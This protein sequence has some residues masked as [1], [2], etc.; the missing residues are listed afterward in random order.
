MEE[1]LQLAQNGKVDKKQA[2]LLKEARQ[3]MFKRSAA[4]R[5]TRPSTASWLGALVVV[6]GVVRW[7]R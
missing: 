1:M 2:L 6:V 5:T 7:L 3:K 4:A